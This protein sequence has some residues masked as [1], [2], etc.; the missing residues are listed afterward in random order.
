MKARVNQADN[1]TTDTESL[2]NQDNQVQNSAEQTFTPWQRIYNDYKK[3]TEILKAKYSPLLNKEILFKQSKDIY[4]LANIFKDIAEDNIVLARASDTNQSLKL[5]YYND[6]AIAC[7]H[8]LS[9]IEKANC[10]ND[11]RLQTL[12]NEVC[13]YLDLIQIDMVSICGGN[14]DLLQHINTKAD[15]NNI[16]KSEI[17]EQLRTKT[18]GQLEAIEA[19]KTAK[20]D[21]AYIEL[22]A[23][24]FKGIASEMENYV[25]MLYKEAEEIL[26][27]PPCNYTVIGLGSMSLRQMTPYSDLEFAILTD[28]DTYKQSEA[29]TVKEYFRNLTH[30]VHFKVINLGETIIPTSAYNINL[31]TFIRQAVNFDLGGKTPLGRIEKDKPYELI[32]TVEEMLSYLKE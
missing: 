5:Q 24:I 8:G 16:S 29:F 30:L 13:S 3:N 19:A 27:T 26:G 15:L 10:N 1:I 31:A 25:A 23:N 11:L 6:S 22:T 28:N 20:N 21:P 32:Q 18:K 14:L 4:S 7:H 17:L 12:E 2:V 9:V